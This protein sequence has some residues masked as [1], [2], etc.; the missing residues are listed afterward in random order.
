MVASVVLMRPG[1]LKG[2]LDALLLAVLEPGPQHGYAVIELCAEHLQRRPGR[3]MPA[4]FLE[5]NT[6]KTDVPT[7]R[8]PLVDEPGV[9]HAADSAC[10]ERPAL[11]AP[12]AGP[13][14]TAHHLRSG[15]S[16]DRK[17]RLEV[18]RTELGVRPPGKPCFKLPSQSM[19]NCEGR[20]RP[21]ED[22][23][24]GELRPQPGPHQSNRRGETTP[25]SPGRRNTAGG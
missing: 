24:D 4:I 14:D 12:V 22:S 13:L 1:L 11:A 17:A 21:G 5:H 18:C 10:A 15:F 3:D 25:M 20:S 23:A 8:H 7:T 2:H 19:R 9:L 16:P 6:P